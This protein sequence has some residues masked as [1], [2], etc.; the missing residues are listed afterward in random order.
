MRLVFLLIEST[1]VLAHKCDA[2]FVFFDCYEQY[3]KK[4]PG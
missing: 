4:R 2:K 1:K 3:A